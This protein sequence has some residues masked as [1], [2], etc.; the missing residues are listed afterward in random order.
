MDFLIIIFVFGGT[1]I[2]TVKLAIKAWPCYSE[3]L[4]SVVQFRKSRI[5]LMNGIISVVQFILLWLIK[6]IS[7]LIIWVLSGLIAGLAVYLVSLFVPG[8]SF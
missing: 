7:C 4:G 8:L 2:G 6:I 3:W 5:R 1:L